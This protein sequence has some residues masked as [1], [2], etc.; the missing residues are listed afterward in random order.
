[1]CVARVPYKIIDETDLVHFSRWLLGFN[2]ATT[3][4]VAACMR[5]PTS[6]PGKPG[7]RDDVEISEELITAPVAQVR[8][9][10]ISRGHNEAN[11]IA[12]GRGPSR[13]L[14]ST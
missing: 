7:S 14:W 13:A 12:C 6:G 11:V 2:G 9:H 4:V 3:T 8:C 10:R 5:G 1:M